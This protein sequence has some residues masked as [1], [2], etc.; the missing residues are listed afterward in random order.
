MPRLLSASICAMIDALVLL[1]RLPRERLGDS[2]P[3]NQEERRMFARHDA[4]RTLILCLSVLALTTTLATGQPRTA[5]LLAVE[6]AEKSGIYPLG[7]EVVF[8]IRPAE[9]AEP[10]AL[11]KV[12][13][14]ITRDGWEKLPG[15][16]AKKAGAALEIRFIPEAAGWYMCEAAPQGSRGATARAGVL[17]D[18]EKIT[19]SVAEPNDLDEFWN[20]RRV[21][22]AAMPL[23]AEMTA[24][25]SPDSQIEIFNV[26]LACPEIKSVRGYYACPR[27]VVKRSAPAILYVR[28]AGVSGDWC[29]ASPRNAAALAKQYGAIV[30]DINAHG[31]LNGQPPEYYRNLEQGEL[32]EYWRQGVDDRDKFYFVGMY[33]RLLRAVEFLASREP[34]DGAHLITIGESQGGGQA[35]AA[36]GLDKRVSAVVALVPAMCDFTGPVVGRVGGWPMPL[37]PDITS[38]SA[39]QIIAAVRYCDNV[40]LARRSRAETLVFVGLIDTTCSP[41]GIYATCNRLPGRKQIVAYPHKPHNGLPPEDRWIGDMSVL[42]DRFLRRHIGR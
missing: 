1:R 23:K 14:T 12:A 21:A 27:N 25:E 13:V 36:A 31:M 30:L 6:S 2:E 34:W 24:V 17:V 42:Q 9:G 28:A 41:A 7:K 4:P 3:G 35:L 26:E 38:D 11:E 33:I 20:V 15:W 16:D 19:P 40:H 32:R 22:L 29:K 8:T 10:N 37:G 5:S 39:K 18:P